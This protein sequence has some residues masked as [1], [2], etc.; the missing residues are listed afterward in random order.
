MG[1]I[2]LPCSHL[3]SNITKPALNFECWILS[4][5]GFQR[6]GLWAKPDQNPIVYM[7]TYVSKEA[8]LRSRENNSSLFWK[9]HSC[10]GEGTKFLRL[11][12]AICT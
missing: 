7:N 9:L 2:F 11:G 5:S 4:K 12:T 3:S 10:G 1:S 6:F 8:N